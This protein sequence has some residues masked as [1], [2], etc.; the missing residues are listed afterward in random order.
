MLKTLV[1]TQLYVHNLGW[2]FE[3]QNLLVGSWQ[4]DP[5]QSDSNENTHSGHLTFSFNFILVNNA[6]FFYF[7]VIKLGH[8]IADIIVFLSYKQSNEK[9]RTG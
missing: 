9:L 7:F 6:Y 4:N 1:A 5:P 3:M 8:F 2:E